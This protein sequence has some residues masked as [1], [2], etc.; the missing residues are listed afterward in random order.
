MV[1]AYSVNSWSDSS[2]KVCAEISAW[3]LYHTHMQQQQLF[4]SPLIQDNPGEPVPETVAYVAYNPTT[5]TIFHSTCLYTSYSGFNVAPGLLW[6][7]LAPAFYCVTT[8]WLAAAT[9]MRV[10]IIPV[11]PALL[12]YSVATNV[13]IFI[14]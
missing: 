8:S 2:I 13:L 7:S 11:S 5:I 10:R 4:H 3:N 14:L 1:S 6:D 9:Q 12:A